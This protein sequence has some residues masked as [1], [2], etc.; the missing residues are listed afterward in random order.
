MWGVLLIPGHCCVGS[1]P[2]MAALWASLPL[3]QSLSGNVMPVVQMLPPQATAAAHD[4]ARPSPFACPVL[5][6]TQ[7]VPS[8]Q[9]Q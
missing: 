1:G 4:Y 7:Q 6:K 5:V 2:D 9:R 8:A 3:P